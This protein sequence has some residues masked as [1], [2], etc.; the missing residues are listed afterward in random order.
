ML[1]RIRLKLKI[2]RLQ[3]EYRR[4][5]ERAY[6]LSNVNRAQSDSKAEEAESV[7]KEI[8]KLQLELIDY[9]AE[10]GF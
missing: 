8:E 2:S 6:E 7:L 9:K 5:L 3:K 1:K 10:A 4:L